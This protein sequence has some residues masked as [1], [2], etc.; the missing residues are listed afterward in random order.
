MMSNTLGVHCF[1]HDDADHHS[2][3]WEFQ[4]DDVK[5]H[6]SSESHSLHD[7]FQKYG[8]TDFVVKAFFSKLMRIPC[9]RLIMSSILNRI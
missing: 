9:N 2:N 6:M 4:R 8:Y 7:D 1:Q 3:S 5:D